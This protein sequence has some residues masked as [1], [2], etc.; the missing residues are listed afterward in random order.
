MSRLELQVKSNSVKIVE[1]LYDDLSRRISNGSASV[2]PVDATRAF[3]QMCHSQTCGKCVPCRVGLLQLENLLTDVLDDKARLDDLDLL[4]ETALSIFDSADCAIGYE[5]AEMVYKS[6][7]YSREDYE[8][9][10]IN[11]RCTC[12][13]GQPVPCVSLCPANVDVP[14]YVALVKDG[15]YE[16]AIRL[17]RKDNPLPTTCAY[18]CEHPCED[19]CRRSMVDSPINIR[20]IKRLAADFAGRV[21]PPA[22]ARKTGKNIAIIGGGPAG[23]TA[24]YYLQL[25]GHQT[26]IYEMLP[27]LGGMLRYG[28]PNY[29]LPKDRL[30]EDIETIL[31]TGVKV[32][33]NVKIGRD[34]SFDKVKNSYDATLITIGASTDKKL[35]LEGEDNEDISSAVEFL[36]NVGLGKSLD[37]DGKKVVVIGGGN[38]AMDAVRTALRLKAKKVTCVYRRR[39]ADMSALEEEIQGA[40][41]EGVELISLKAPKK[42]KIVDGRVKGIY[43]SPQMISEIKNGRA[44]LKPSLEEDIFIECDKI[45]VAIGQNIETSHYE[46]NGIPVERGKIF[47]LANGGFKGLPNIFSGGDCASGPATV[48]KAIAAGKVMAANIDQYL[49]YNTQ[50]SVDV[51]IPEVDTVYRQPCA[52]SELHL[53]EAGERKFDF[54]EI[55]K[56][57]SESEALQEASRCLRCDHYG[58]GIFKGGREKLW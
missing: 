33:H 52:R 38:V 11:K 23:L 27:K 56:C 12:H 48:I 40:L 39:V 34:I 32:I 36:R 51:E 24:A 53:R 43:V 44:S 6:V 16:D 21:D 7:R 57:L 26:T 25:M 42:I 1:D 5:A 46:D 18:I 9:H 10:I 30:D 2:C 41:A 3:V 31:K 29:R 15:R 58:F 37:L 47:S 4:E 22:N 54:D 20:A 13:T 14:G 45:I 19:R 50:I 49:G 55:E 17:I 8:N 28:I 35:G